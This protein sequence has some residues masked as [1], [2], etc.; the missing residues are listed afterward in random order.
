[1]NQNLDKCIEM[2]PHH[3]GGFVNHPSDPDGVTNRSVTMK[4]SDDFYGDDIDKERI[5]KITVDDIKPIYRTNYWERCRCQDLP[6]G[7]D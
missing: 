4:T 1:M 7:V 3:E 5:K 6:S 2:L